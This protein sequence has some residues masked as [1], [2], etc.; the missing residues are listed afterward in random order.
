MSESQLS[1]FRLSSLFSSSILFSFPG[2]RSLV[3]HFELGKS[4]KEI[5]LRKIWKCMGLIFAKNCPPLHLFMCLPLQNLSFLSEFLFIFAN[6][7]TNLV[8]SAWQIPKHYLL[9]DIQNISTSYFRSIVMLLL[10]WRAPS[11][12]LFKLWPLFSFKLSWTSSSEILVSIFTNNSN[13]LVCSVR[14]TS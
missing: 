13:V 2:A 8:H 10:S 3:A 4:Y 11:V 9:K 5:L 14:K 12:Y 6:S 1:N 7:V